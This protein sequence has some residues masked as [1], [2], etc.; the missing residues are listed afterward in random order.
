MDYILYI[1]VYIWNKIYIDIDIDIYKV[2]V[3]L[4]TQSCT[5]L[6]YTMDCLSMG[7]LQARI[8]EDLPNP[9]F[10]PGSPTLQADSLPAEPPGKPYTI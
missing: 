7:I 5:T 6:C 4:V 1:Y 3:C 9:G 8:P 10:K 2:C